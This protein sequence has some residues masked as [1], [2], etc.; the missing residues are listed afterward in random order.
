MQQRKWGNL[1]IFEESTINIIAI[2]SE[3]QLHDIVGFPVC[4]LQVIA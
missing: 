4:S 3:A 2:N 1:P